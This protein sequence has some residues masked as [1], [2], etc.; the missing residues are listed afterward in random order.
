MNGKATR[1]GGIIERKKREPRGSFFYFGAAGFTV[2]ELVAVIIIMGILAAVVLPR[3]SA[4]TSGFDEVRLY[5]QTLA[6]LRYAQNTAV[7]TQ[8]TVCANFT[9]AVNPTTLTLR[10]SNSYLV[11]A[12][13]TDLIPP[14]GGA[15]PHTVVGQGGAQFL[16]ASDLSFS[17]DR[18]GRPSAARTIDLVGGRQIVVEAD[19]GYVR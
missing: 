17:Y 16:S 1:E 13:D 7:A 15:A 10:Y 5:D 12:C 6:A 11:P 9:P 14:G 19:T 8:R 2:A 3:F 4:G 18:V